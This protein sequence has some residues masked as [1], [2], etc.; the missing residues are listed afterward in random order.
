DG[1]KFINLCRG[2]AADYES[3]MDDELEDEES[4]R[5]SDF[6]MESFEEEQ[7]LPEE[8]EDEASSSGEDEWVV[9]QPQ[10]SE[11]KFSEDKAENEVNEDQSGQPVASETENKLAQEVESW[12]MEVPSIIGQEKSESEIEIPGVISNSMAE[13]E[14]EDR[15]EEAALPESSDLE[16]P[17]LGAMT[18]ESASTKTEE[19][20]S[21]RSQLI[22]L[23]DL[24]VDEDS[25]EV[26]TNDI[27]AGSAGG[28]DTEEGV[29]KLEEQIRD[30]VEDQEEDLWAAD[31]VEDGQEEQASEEEPAEEEFKPF[32]S[33]SVDSVELESVEMDDL[34]R[35]QPHSLEDV[36]DY[37]EDQTPEDF[38]E[39]IMQEDIMQEDIMQEDIM[40]EENSEPAASAQTYA[41][42]LSAMSEEIQSKLEKELE[43]K[44]SPLVE[45]FVK[46]YCKNQ[47]EKVAW[48]VIP[49]LAEN[50]IKKEI[51]KISDS[52]MDQ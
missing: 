5:D 51:Q 21:P 27:S 16:Y 11:E 9:N 20:A 2:M 33:E 39:D 10:F 40:Q 41:P 25:F 26:E 8:I 43:Q 36:S 6:S 18:S 1:T 28:T 42:D 48:E 30:E 44:L 38:P 19:E 31:I 22:S 34:P 4:S 37:S 13:A 32:S 14:P 46:D 35:V 49:D 50:I 45:R 52:I 29:R 24:K 7:E 17:D 12:G 3:Y 23:S 15:D 47:I